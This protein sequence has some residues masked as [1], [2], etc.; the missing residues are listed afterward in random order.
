MANWFLP[1]WHRAGGLALALCL[2]SAAAA[3]AEPHRARLSADLADHLAAGSS[4]ID[5]IVHGD[6]GF[7]AAL[8]A[9]YN[10][11]VAKRLASGAVLRVTAGQL[12][13]LRQDDSVDHLSGDIRIR[14][15][16][17]VTTETIAA[18]QVWAGSTD[19]P[20]LTGAGVT[21]AVIDSGI[22]TRHSAF[23]GGRVIASRDFTGGD[24]SDQFGHGTH[25]AAIIA[26]Q[27]GATAETRAYRGVAAG[28]YLVNLRVLGA[29]G[30][31]MASDVVEAI[32]WA[33]AHRNDY[34]IAV[35]NLS[36]GAPVLQPYRDDPL[37]E[38]VE[39]AVRAG[40]TVVVAAGNAGQT[41]DGTP[42]FGT[43]TSPGNS[44]HALT[45]GA[46][47]THGT[48]DRA[49][50]TLAAYSSKGPTRYDLVLKPD[51][52][53]PG[54][55]VVSAE[56]AGSYLSTTYPARHVAGSGS[57]AYIQLSGTSMA[58]GVVSGAVALLLEERAEM[59]PRQV[60]AALQMSSTYLA[61]AGLVGAGAGEID[62]AAAVRL[63]SLRGAASRTE[64]NTGPTPR[65]VFNATTAGVVRG[66]TIYWADTTFWG[67]TI[68][69]VSATLRSNTIFWGTTAKADTIFWGTTCQPD[70]IYWG[71]V[72]SDTIYWG[73]TA[74]D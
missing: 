2:A 10:L 32:D 26:G 3:H 73:T 15:V 49:D 44:P 35:I 72:T 19:V 42:A 8:A 28:A 31:G 17:D 7:V 50:D 6:P 40:I 47:D 34:R 16:G 57:N 63:L 56:A 67:T 24:G 33:V 22:D 46:I 29:D 30:S 64:A 21:V 66:S 36:L 23:L 11:V 5:V 51:L 52:A 9:R 38:A 71:T 25:V 48:A 55:H 53:A 54:S 4:S 13:V 18:D 43:I 69:W 68:S 37:C 65:F 12:D 41:A 14:S 59:G 20:A 58:A 70:T 27:G 1:S 74:I 62:A 39:R 45:V 61:A 60:K